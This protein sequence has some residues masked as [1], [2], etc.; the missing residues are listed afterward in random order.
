MV[1]HCAHIYNGV[2]YTIT[3]LFRLRDMRFIKHN[4]CGISRDDE[5]KEKCHLE[6]GQN[7]L[8][9]CSTGWNKIEKGGNP[10]NTDSLPALPIPLPH[11]VCLG[12]SHMTVNY[13]L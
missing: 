1:F 7:N 2:S 12:L 5:V 3:N 10:S 6:C 9:G 8:L 11:D 4:L 13:N